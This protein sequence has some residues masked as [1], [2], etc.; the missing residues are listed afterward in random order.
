MRESALGISGMYPDLGSPEFGLLPEIRSGFCGAY[1]T[2]KC[3]E[4]RF[5]E[6]SIRPH[7]RAHIDAEGSDLLDRL[8]HVFRLQSAGK[9]DDPLRHCRFRRWVAGGHLMQYNPS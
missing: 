2:E 4:L 7:S 6:A 8:S 5:V 1:R 3:R 9:K